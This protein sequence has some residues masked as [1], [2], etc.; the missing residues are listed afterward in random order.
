[1]D[2]RSD[3][4]CMEALNALVAFIEEYERGTR[5]TDSSGDRT[6]TGLPGSAVRQKTLAKP[7]REPKAKARG[8]C[9]GCGMGCS[10]SVIS[11][12]IESRL[13]RR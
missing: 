1:M 10:S 12:P 8:G 9:L 11:G 13:G 7:I 5:R 4:A 6:A 2:D 3:Q